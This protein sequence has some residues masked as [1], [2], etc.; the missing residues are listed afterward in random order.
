LYHPVTTPLA[1]VTLIDTIRRRDPQVPQ[2]DIWSV[3]VYRGLSFGSLFSDY[4]AISGKPLVI[5]EY[6]IDAYDNRTGN[7]YELTGPPQQ[8]IYAQ[9]LW[10]EIAAHS[11]VC[12]GGS[13]MEYCDEWWKGKYGV[14]DAAHPAC[15]DY[16]ASEHSTC[17]YSNPGVH[18]DRYANEEWWGIMRTWDN[19]AEPDTMQ[20]RAAYCVLQS[21]WCSRLSGDMDC[22]CDV[23]IVDIMLVARR[24]MSWIGEP[25][26]HPCY[27]LDGDENID[28]V[29]IMRVALHWGESCSS[30]PSE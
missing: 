26:Y 22:D 30:A 11:D 29:D 2:L 28:I 4:A 10:T 14:T 24:W 17:G 1:D 19:G 18:P 8:A 15:P 6:G 5:T 12:A 13:I 20:P 7:E 23:D 3:Q 25:R 16:S 21:L 9:A 27:D